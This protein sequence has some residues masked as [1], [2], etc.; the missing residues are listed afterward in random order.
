VV[1]GRPKWKTTATI[2]KLKKNVKNYFDT[3]YLTTIYNNKGNFPF[4]LLLK[5]VIYP[6][7]VLFHKI[8]YYNKITIFLEDK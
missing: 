7:T 1:T 4:T 8:L 2:L 5:K 3:L 6:T